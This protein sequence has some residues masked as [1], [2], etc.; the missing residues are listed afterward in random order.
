VQ[1][2][3]TPKKGV[4]IALDANG[5]PIDAYGNRAQTTNYLL[6]GAAGLMVLAAVMDD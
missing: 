5:F 6:W 1:G 3:T 4:P 2:L